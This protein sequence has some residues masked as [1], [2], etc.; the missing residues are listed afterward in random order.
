VAPAVKNHG[1]PADLMQSQFDMSKKFFELPLE[2]KQAL[3]FDVYLDIGYQAPKS[4]SLDPDRA[5][6]KTADTKVGA[7]LG[8]QLKN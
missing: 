3:P 7:A 6:Q 1:V 8:A 2:V 4:Q 5:T